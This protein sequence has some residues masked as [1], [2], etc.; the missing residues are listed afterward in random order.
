M[1]SAQ[2]A[3]SIPETRAPACFVLFPKGAGVVKAHCPGT[4][5][6]PLVTA[7]LPQRLRI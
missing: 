3:H 5:A 2:A 4:I 6:V 1:F 7:S